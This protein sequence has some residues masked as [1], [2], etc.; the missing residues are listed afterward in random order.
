ML[1]KDKIRKVIKENPEGFTIDLN[2]DSVKKTDGFFIG[3]TNIKGKNINQLIQRVLFIKKTGF[4]G[5]NNLL[6]GG[7]KDENK[8][9]Y[10][11]LSLYCEDLNK[12]LFLGKLFN[13]KAI[14]DIKNLKSINL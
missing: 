12:S 5:T 2:A 9:F 13:Q 3:I 4:K 8:T 14:F 7:W 6:I 11:D 1:N 10:L